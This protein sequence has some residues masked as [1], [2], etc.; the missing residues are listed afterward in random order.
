[1]LELLKPFKERGDDSLLINIGSADAEFIGRREIIR[2]HET[3]LGN[4]ITKSFKEKFNAD[5]AVANSG[6]IRD[7]IYPGEIKIET[8]LMVLPFAGE[9]VTAQLTGKELKSYLEAVIKNGTPGLGSFPQMSGVTIVAAKN[10]GKIKTLKVNGKEVSAS[11]KY[12]I[13]LPEF[14]ANGGDK[15]PVLK[16][17][18]YGYVDADIL[19]EFILKNPLLQHKEF[20]PT[21]YLTFD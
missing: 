14:I 15:Y 3:N 18:K 2:S 6:G 20:A 4:L 16:Y 11:K 10:T 13:A 17:R 7:S 9:V 21:G 12:V 8:V 19:K 1:M 5:I